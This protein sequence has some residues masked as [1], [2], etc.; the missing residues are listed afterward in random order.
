MKSAVNDYQVI[1]PKTGK[2]VAKLS[3][4]NELERLLMALL[5][6]KTGLVDAVLLRR[7]KPELDVLISLGG[8]FHD[9]SVTRGFEKEYN[10]A[11][12]TNLSGDWIKL[13]E[14]IYNEILDRYA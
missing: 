5:S 1:D 8:S 2:L 4:R 6:A 10:Q 7:R 9:V 13:I 11:A 14:S 12:K 3:R